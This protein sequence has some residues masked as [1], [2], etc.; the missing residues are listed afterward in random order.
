MA[1]RCSFCNGHGLVNPL[2]ALSIAGFT[3]LFGVGFA[4]TM[5]R[6]DERQAADLSHALEVQGAITA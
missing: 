6:Y 3:L 5:M 4:A 1:L 2:D